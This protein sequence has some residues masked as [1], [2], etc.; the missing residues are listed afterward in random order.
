[1]FLPRKTPPEPPTPTVP[2]IRAHRQ[3]RL[4]GATGRAGMAAAG[5]SGD[6]GASPT[7]PFPPPVLL[8]SPPPGFGDLFSLLTNSDF[9]L[10]GT[11]S[12]WAPYGSAV[13]QGAVD[14]RGPPP[15][16]CTWATA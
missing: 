12:G 16:A 14:L 11:P 2:S 5:G 9:E 7:L 6:V 15:P 13:L 10:W 8:L 1:M 3:P 4:L